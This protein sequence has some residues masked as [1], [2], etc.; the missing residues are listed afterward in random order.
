MSSHLLSPPVWIDQPAQLKRL[1][2]K[3]AGQKRIAVDTE[4]NSLYAYREQVCLIQFSTVSKDYLVDPLALDDLGPL[5]PIFADPGIE[6]VFHAAEY[7]VIC[8]RRDFGYAFANLFDT[9]QAAR[10]LGYKA[11]GLNTLLELKFDVSLDKR[12][13]KANWGA[14]PLPPAQVDYARFDTH[15]LLKL[16]DLLYAEL[17]ESGR[18]NLAEEDFER[19]CE[20]PENNAPRNNNGCASWERAAK[21][22]DLT[23][24]QETILKTLYDSREQIAE[25]M[26][27]PPFKVIDDKRLLAIAQTLPRSLNDLKAVGVSERQLRYAGQ[28]LLEAVN[29]GEIAPLVSRH[30]NERPSDDYITRVEALKSWRKAQARKMGVESD[31]ILPRAY[32]YAIARDNPNSKDQLESVLGTPSWRLS[33]YSSQILDVLRE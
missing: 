28:S 6:K 18:W 14:R 32:I 4:S 33:K 8:L 30:R 23:H 29:E 7:D 12:Y 11:V 26:D 10:I 21:Q 25:R 13:Q 20:T 16:R 31:V 17:G 19:A 3:L 15:Y 24:R 2:D 27:R 22:H 1:V 5:A 9:M